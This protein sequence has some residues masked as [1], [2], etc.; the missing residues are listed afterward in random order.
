[1]GKSIGAKVMADLFHF[2]PKMSAEEREKKY[3]EALKKGETPTPSPKNIVTRCEEHENGRIFYAN[4]KG[5]SRYT[6]F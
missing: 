3:V 1:M 5:V 2:W 4:E 6:V